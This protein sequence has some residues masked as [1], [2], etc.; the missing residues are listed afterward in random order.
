MLETGYPFRVNTVESR[1]FIPGQKIQGF[2]K[3]RSFPFPGVVVL[4]PLESLDS[5]NVRRI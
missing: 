2:N 4:T 5:R 3:F 1:V